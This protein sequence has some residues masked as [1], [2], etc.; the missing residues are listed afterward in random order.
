M[1]IG[2]RVKRVKFTYIF[3]LNFKVICGNERKT[4]KTRVLAEITEFEDD[5]N[6]RLRKCRN[7]S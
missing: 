5:N 2:F 7:L 4:R 6:V 3:V 1:F